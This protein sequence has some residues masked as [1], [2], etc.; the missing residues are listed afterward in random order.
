MGFGALL[1]ALQEVVCPCS[2]SAAHA[3]VG[4]PIPGITSAVVAGRGAW[5]RVTV[6]CTG[7]RKPLC[8]EETRWTDFAGLIPYAIITIDTETVVDGGA[9]KW[10]EHEWIRAAGDVLVSGAVAFLG[11]DLAHFLFGR[12]GDL[13]ISW[14]AL[15][16]GP[17]G[18][19]A[20]C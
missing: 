16:L 3:P 6:G 9:L 10:A 13:V 12:V 4:T 8:A 7:F 14:N 2:T 15:A 1:T 5:K 20:R 17:A 19:C 18:D 11:T